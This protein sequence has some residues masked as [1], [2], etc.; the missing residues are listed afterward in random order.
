MKSSLLVA[1]AAIFACTCGEFSNVPIASA[2][3]TLVFC[4]TAIPASSKFSLSFKDNTNRITGGSNA[5][6]NQLPYQVSI[7]V[8][9]FTDFEHF[10]GGSIVS[11]TYVVTSGYCITEL[12][13]RTT[14]VAAGI[15]NL[16]KEDGS[17]SNI[18]STL[19]HPSF[20]G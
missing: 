5:A 10:C 17:Y 12:P 2:F 15:L 14:R 7:Q 4:Q 20:E 19:V 18:A 9:Y 11:P 13:D 6:R 3:L 8:K 16:N 1:L